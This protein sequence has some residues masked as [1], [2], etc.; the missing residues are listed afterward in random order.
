MTEQKERDRPIGYWLKKADELL[1]TRIDEAQRTNGLTR[2][3]WQML[4]VVRASGFASRDRIT[5]SL[6]P[7]A[8]ESAIDDMLAKLLGQHVII[9]FDEKGYAL[10]GA[11]EE[12]YQRALASQKIVRQ[13]AVA[14]ITDAEYAATISVLQ[15]LVK[16]LEHDGAT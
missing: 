5:E 11:G 3:G 2:L 9:G 14:G 12:L 8:R 4:N 16:N 10:T 15:R 7:F 13:N 6:R 1:T